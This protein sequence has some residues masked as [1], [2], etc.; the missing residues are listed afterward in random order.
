MSNNKNN[1]NSNVVEIVYDDT[2]EADLSEDAVSVRSTE[3]STVLCEQ[4]YSVS[5]GTCRNISGRLYR[6]GNGEHEYSG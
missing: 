6:Q 3:M 2:I 4:V 5:T 1:E